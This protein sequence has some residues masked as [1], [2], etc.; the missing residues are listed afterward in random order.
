MKVSV[1]GAGSTYTPEVMEGFIRRRESFPVHEL[2]LMDIDQRK[3][4][5]VGGL[6][7]RMAAHSAPDMT[8][9]LTMDLDDALKGSSFVLGQIRVGR[10]PARYLD[11]SIPLKYG[12]IGQET[13][14]MGG[15][16]NGLRTIPQL[17]HI[18]RRMEVLCP[19][20]WL[21]NFSNPS[22]MVAEAL[23]RYSSI[24]SIGLCNI[25]INTIADMKT[26]VGSEDITIETVGLNHLSWVTSVI[27]DGREC[28]PELIE[29]GYCGDK[30]ANLPKISF[31][32]DCMRACGG[33]P[34][35]YLVY[36]YD[37][38]HQLNKLQSAS[39][40]RAQVCM[41]IEESLLK[42]Y[43][44]EGLYSSPELLNKRGGHLYSEAAV[45]LADSIYNDTGDIHTVN[46]QNR[47]VLPYLDKTEVAEIACRVTRNGAEPLPIKA[48]GTPHMIQLIQTIKA[49][50]RLAVEAAV[51]GDRDAAMAAMLSHPLI[52]DYDKASACFT[53]M[54]EAHKT[55]LPQFFN[56]KEA[57]F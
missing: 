53:E 22:G 9:R 28:L 39:R 21:I 12:F 18:A 40:T 44:D 15:F 3:L 54:L 25:P 7:Q 43:Q 31:S 49:Y 42:L 10:L 8:V 56:P 20:A 55:Y 52:G 1:I 17:L 36:Y 35:C 34:N 19:D 37:R 29:R 23:L 38:V 11:E 14:G 47:G 46:V 41:E 50:E 27:K 6:I 24:R 51:R 45:S 26:A 48:Q 13:T 33:I 32:S 4:S 30:P 57:V 5:I 16:M 2:V